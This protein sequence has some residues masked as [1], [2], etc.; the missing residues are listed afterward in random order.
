MAYMIYSSGES[1]VF[2]SKFTGWEG[3]LKEDYSV[4][5]GEK[6]ASEKRAPKV[7][8]PHYYYSSYYILQVDLSPLFLPRQPPMSNRQAVSHHSNY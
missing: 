3:V 7:T 6:K 2:K 4:V 8:N 5:K 1:F